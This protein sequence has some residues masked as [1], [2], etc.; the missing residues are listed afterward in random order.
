MNPTQNCLSP[1]VK[2]F[3]IIALLENN[4]E[5]TSFISNF[6]VLE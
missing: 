5:E 6:L 2:K 3:T 1:L 4:Q